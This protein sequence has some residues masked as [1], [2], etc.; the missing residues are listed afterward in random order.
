[1]PYEFAK[2]EPRPSDHI[3][4]ITINRPDVMNAL[5]P[6]AARELSK[7]WDDFAADPELWVAILT[8]AGDRAFSAGNDLKYVP[9]PDDPGLPATGWGGFLLRFDMW[10][11]TIAAVNGWAVGGGMEMTVA[12]DIAIASENARFSLPEVRL[13]GVATD[14]G[15]AHRLPRHVPMKLAM[16]ILLTGDAIDAREAYRA[17]LVNE[18]V[19]PEQLMPAAER[20]AQRIVRAS[21]LAVRATKEAAALG[22]GLPLD[23]AVLRRYPGVESLAT[24]A[25]REE[26]RRAAVEGREPRWQGR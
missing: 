15:G 13:G 17:G 3:A 9:E 6:P 22:A 1:M 5:H 20:W 14:S 12:C 10:K 24:S 16:A 21:P 23:A 18:V 11:P 19:P 7:I 4:V 2:Y 26:S 8:G 25:D